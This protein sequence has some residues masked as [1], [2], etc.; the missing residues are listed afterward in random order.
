MT[1]DSMEHSQ[2]EDPREHGVIAQEPYYEPASP[3]S[4]LSPPKSPSPKVPSVHIHTPT[5][6]IRNLP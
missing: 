3:K 4:P 2:W 6:R 5:N 1:D